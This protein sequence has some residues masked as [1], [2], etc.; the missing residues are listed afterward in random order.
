MPTFQLCLR[1]RKEI[2]ISHGPTK[3]LYAFKYSQT[4]V[5]CRRYESFRGQASFLL[6]HPLTYNRTRVR[7]LSNGK[8][9]TRGKIILNLVSVTSV[10]KETLRLTFHLRARISRSSN[11]SKSCEIAASTR[12]RE[13]ELSIS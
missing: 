3:F 9:N 7:F 8:G 1:F 12:R 4:R 13:V 11:L 6:R 2:C 10:P 5:L